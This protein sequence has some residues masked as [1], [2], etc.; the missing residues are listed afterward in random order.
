MIDGT[1]EGMVIRQAPRLTIEALGAARFKV[2]FLVE[3]SYPGY[4]QFDFYENG[5]PRPS[6]LR[7]ASLLEC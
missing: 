7:Q 4:A 6:Q 2:I 5:P 3:T 1:P